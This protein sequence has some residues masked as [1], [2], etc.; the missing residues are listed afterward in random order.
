MRKIFTGY[1]PR[2]WQ[3]YIHRKLKRFNVVPTHRRL[4]KTVMFDNEII[5]QGLRLKR[6][7]PQYGYIG[8]NYGQVKRTSWEYMKEFSSKFPG[9]KFNESEL[10]IEIPRPQVGDK[11]K[12]LLLSSENYNSLKGLYLDG[13]VLDEYQEMNP[14]VWD[15]V[16]RPALSDRVGWACFSGTAK[17][18]NH[19]YDIHEFAK[20]NPN[21]YTEVF[22]VSKT[23]IIP[24]SELIDLR[25]TMSPEAYAQ[26]YECDF[27]AALVGAYYGKHMAKAENEGRIT[28]VPHQPQL[29]VH[30]FWDLGIDDHLAIWFMQESGREFHFIDYLQ[31]SD[32]GLDDICKIIKEKDYNFGEHN[33]PHDAKARELGTGK[34]REE[35]LKSLGL[36]RLRVIQ[37][38]KLEDKINATRMILPRCWFDQIKCKDGIDALK[39]YQR[40]WDAKNA[41]FSDH[42]LHNWASHGASAFSEF[43]IGYRD[44]SMKMDGKGLPRTSDNDYDIYEY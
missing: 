5:D 35:T 36:K 32:K 24:E 15:V 25:N 1:T 42:P 31:V 23:K 6:R 27:G 11:V 8:P 17:G 43:A 2:Y 18:K 13:A 10:R 9:V 40:E 34:T 38:Q 20:T 19:F 28:N 14:Q 3:D 22:P 39:N 16:V 26:E 44:A 7:N 12:I 37:K 33:L 21:W 29:E 4:G 30:T 41:I